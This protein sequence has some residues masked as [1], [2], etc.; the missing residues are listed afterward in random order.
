MRLFAM[1]RETIERKE[2]GGGTPRFKPRGAGRESYGK[3]QGR[4][5]VEGPCNV[6]IISINV[7]TSNDKIKEKRT[8]EQFFF[9]RTNNSR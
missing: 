6:M 8:T 4:F 3:E 9:V 7:L 5:S 2:C 1:R